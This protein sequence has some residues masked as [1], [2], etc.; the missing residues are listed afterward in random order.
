MPDPAFQIDPSDPRGALIVL[1]TDPPEVATAKRQMLKA[2]MET[3]IGGLASAP[4]MGITNAAKIK[5]VSEQGVELEGVGVV[6]WQAVEISADA[7]PDAEMDAALGTQPATAPPPKPALPGPAPA[8]APSRTKPAN[9]RPNLAD[10][11][12]GYPLLVP[13]WLGSLPVPAESP[14][15][16]VQ[17]VTP[18]PAPAPSPPSPDESFTMYRGSSSGLLSSTPTLDLSALDQPPGAGRAE[19]SMESL[20]LD[21]SQPGAVPAETN[22]TTKNTPIRW[23]TSRWPTPDEFDRVLAEEEAKKARTPLL[24][25]R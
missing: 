24:F 17:P 18:P 3:F 14:P 9:G 20:L 23:P 6:P 1:P 12:P 5:S 10:A 4:S 16:S 7:A 8:E 22:W 19:P 11:A 25:G 15:Q 13:D 2:T 21:L